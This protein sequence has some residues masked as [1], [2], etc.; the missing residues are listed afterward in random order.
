MFPV[1]NHVTPPFLGVEFSIISHDCHIFSTAIFHLINQCL[2]M[3]IPHFQPCLP[4]FPNVHR[5]FSSQPHVH[6]PAAA[7]H[8]SLR[9][10][11]QLQTAPTEHRAALR[12]ASASVVVSENGS[13]KMG[14][15]WKCPKIWEKWMVK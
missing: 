6:F 8:P 5:G 3:K 9:C 7:V 10:Q 14:V 1:I 2:S 12:T 15:V 13:W 11:L 4:H